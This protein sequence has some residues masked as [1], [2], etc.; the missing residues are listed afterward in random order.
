MH[1]GLEC[2][3]SIEIQS[4]QVARWCPCL[5]RVD[6]PLPL[7]KPPGCVPRPLVASLS[8][9]VGSHIHD[10]PS[11]CEPLPWLVAGPFLDQREPA[12]AHQLGS[13]G[14][15]M[16]RCIV[17][18]DFWPRATHRDVNVRW[19][20]WTPRSLRQVCR[21]ITAAIARAMPL[22]WFWRLLPMMF[23]K[24]ESVA[25]RSLLPLVVA[26]FKLSSK[27]GGRERKCVRLPWRS[28]FSSWSDVK[29]ARCC[30]WKYA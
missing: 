28:S 9:S 6:F 25:K 20:P 21:D 27:E 15:P 1:V 10:V 26:A 17:G 7:H 19:H 29:P 24:G 13:W 3:G 5:R 18:C 22:G 14:Y 4:L 11:G 23:D 12:V 2:V 30:L 8:K 16:L